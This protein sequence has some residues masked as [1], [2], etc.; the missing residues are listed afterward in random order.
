MKTLTVDTNCEQCGAFYKIKFSAATGK[1]GNYVCAKCNAKNVLQNP[2]AA[3]NKA[4]TMAAGLKTALPA[5]SPPVNGQPVDTQLPARAEPVNGE[6]EMTALARAYPQRIGEV[7]L[8]DDD[9]AVRIEDTWYY[10]AHGRLLPEALRDRWEEFASYR[11]YNYSLDLPPIRELDEEAK[12]RLKQR[13]EK[14]VENPPT[15]HQG[16]LAHL[17]RA[18]TRGETEAA[19]VALLAEPYP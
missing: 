11:F 17:Y 15:R 10:W 16:F 12:L 7:A 14:S 8:R 4:S 6:L 9:W 5:A 19:I 13:L 3:G 2:L 1:V 18:A